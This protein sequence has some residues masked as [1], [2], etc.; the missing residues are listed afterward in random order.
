MGADLD[1]IPINA[2]PSEPPEGF[3]ATLDEY[4]RSYQ[5]EDAE[6]CARKLGLAWH[7]SAPPQ[8]PVDA[9]EASIGYYLAR[10]ASAERAYRERVFR[11]RWAEG[12][13]ISGRVPPPHGARPAGPARPRRRFDAL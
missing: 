12:R 1:P 13:D 7:S 5:Y 8:R 11:A 10:E 6:R 9:Q 2:P 3:A 4:K